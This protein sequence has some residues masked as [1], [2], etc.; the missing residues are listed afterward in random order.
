M[1]AAR[2]GRSLTQMMRAH[3]ACLTV[4]LAATPVAAKAEEDPGLSVSAG[5]GLPELLHVDVGYFVTERWQVDARWANVLFNPMVGVGATRW[6][7]F[8]ESTPRHAML[9]SA[10]AM[11]NPT[12]GFASSGDQIGAAVGG[13][14]GYGFM[15]A[16]GFSVRALAGGLG[17][18]DDG[19]AGGPNV[20]VSLG[21][22][23]R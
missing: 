7:G 16:A 17:Y 11:V 13:S 22:A 12:S 10:Q 20:T 9:V 2:D 14:V 1:H 6:L 23:L 4:V 19:L 15:S 18:W 5:V 8:G 3:L 21:W